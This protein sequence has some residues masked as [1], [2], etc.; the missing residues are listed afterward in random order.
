MALALA[1]SL[2]VGGT[3]VADAVLAQDVSSFEVTAVITDRG[4]SIFK[5]WDY[6][7][8]KSFGVES[9]KTARRGRVLAA[10]VLFKGCRADSAGNCN[11]DVDITAYDPAGK[12][13]GSM[14]GVELWQSER[15]PAPGVMQLSRSYLG[16]VIEP[17]DPIG[18]YRIVVVAHDNIAKAE[19]KSEVSFQVGM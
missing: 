11:A 14:P 1:V 18:T 7:H 17:R 3:F 2:G 9:I 13:Y 19:A 6:A 16:L 5:A 10:L 4:E 15:A 12:V 8:P